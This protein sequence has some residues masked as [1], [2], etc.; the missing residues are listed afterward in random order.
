MRFALWIVSLGAFLFVAHNAS[1]KRLP[2]CSLLLNTPQ[3]SAKQIEEIRKLV[4][5]DLETDSDA[6]ALIEFNDN[7]LMAL[8]S[9]AF[10]GDLALIKIWIPGT[11][12]PVLHYQ[13][14]RYAGH[15]V[16]ATIHP[17]LLMKTPNR[18]IQNLNLMSAGLN[19]MS[20]SIPELAEFN[21][22][23]NDQRNNVTISVRFSKQELRFH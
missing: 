17:W 18:L 20:G 22:P 4:L 14:R 12:N 2:L 7:I 6:S 1:A 21:T 19:L 13:L 10:H 9:P 15:F 23:E 8:A 5:L 3:F 11:I 16:V